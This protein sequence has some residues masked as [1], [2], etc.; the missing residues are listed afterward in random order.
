MRHYK[1]HSVA[2]APLPATIRPHLGSQF[3]LDVHQALKQPT[4]SGQSIG[5]RGAHRSDAVELGA[6]AGLGAGHTVSALPTS[7][8]AL[9]SQA[10][11]ALSLGGL[12]CSA[13]GEVLTPLGD[14]YHSSAPSMA[15]V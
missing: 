2:H 4:H 9:R 6:R 10:A 12:V 1:R 11:Q 3:L 8:L 5:R 15:T 7:S 14:A 13:R